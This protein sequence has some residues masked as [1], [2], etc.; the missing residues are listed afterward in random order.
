[1]IQ[2]SDTEPTLYGHSLPTQTQQIA[3]HADI[4][5]HTG[6][7]LFEWWQAGILP[8]VAIVFGYLSLK[9]KTNAA[10]RKRKRRYEEQNR[11]DEYSDDTIMDYLKK[12]KN[13][14]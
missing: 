3:K 2:Q 10:N 11:L 13:D 9:L 7:T 1:M 5:A 6:A 4:E 14:E 8:V 12:R